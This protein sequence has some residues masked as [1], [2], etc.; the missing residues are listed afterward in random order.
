MI[1]MV[2]GVF[3]RAAAFS[4][5]CCSHAEFCCGC[6]CSR[7]A[8][9]VMMFLMIMVL[10]VVHNVPFGLLNGFAQLT[11]H[12]GVNSRVKRRMRIIANGVRVYKGYS[13]NNE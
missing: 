5:R 3:G 8:F 4:A 9:G 2:V 13:F 7:I 12:P 10:L 1:V 11:L 6:G